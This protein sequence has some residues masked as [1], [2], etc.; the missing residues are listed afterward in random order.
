MNKRM[1]FLTLPLLLLAAV[2]AIPLS[3][4]PVHALT[5]VVCLGDPS[6]VV[7]TAP[8]PAI[9]PT[10]TAPVTTTIATQLKVGVYLSGSDPMNGF[11]VTLL[12]DHTVLLP[13]DAD[14][15]GSVLNQATPAGTPTVIVKCIG[16]ILKAGSTCDAT[17]DSVDTIHFGAIAALG[18][19]T[20]GSTT[21]LLFT[22]VYNVTG[23]NAPGGIVIN[24]Q[25]GCINT[26]VTGF[27]VT[28]TNGTTSPPVETA[29]TAGFDDST[30][31]TSLSWVNITATP[32]NIGPVTPSSQFFTVTA[33]AQN[34][35]PCS[36]ACIA[37]G[38]I[39]TDS[40]SFSFQSAPALIASFS[41][42]TCVT[43]GTTCTDTL[44]VM[45]S[46]PPGNYGITIFG[47][48]KAS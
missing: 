48:F 7:L 4:L 39:Q 21:G 25:T 19:I 2:V 14:L 18:S 23:L 45:P 35:W 30:F 10:F 24:Y 16:G 8:C 32:Q 34:G 36:A 41:T 13:A 37:A 42:P 33:H 28:I 15:T 27:C 47:N 5:G 46:T 1:L 9:T 11:G 17:T 38:S 22:A 20:L 44:T 31:T 43:G 6:T 29:S 26:S 3:T 12:A 40:V